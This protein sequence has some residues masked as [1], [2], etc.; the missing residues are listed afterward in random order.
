MVWPRD[1]AA[2]LSCHKTPVKAEHTSQVMESFSIDKPSDRGIGRHKGCRRC[3]P[4]LRYNA[5]RSQ[6][7]R[8]SRLAQASVCRFIGMHPINNVV[9]ITNYTY[10]TRSASRCIAF[11]AST[12]YEGRIVVHAVLSARNLPLDGVERKLEGTDLMICDGIEP[13]CIAGVFGG[14]D[15]GV[16]EATTDIFLESAC[17]NPTSVRRTARRLRA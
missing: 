13:K 11:D 14:L 8:E 1:L 4:L 6:G 16:T 3:Y 12:L 5:S 2:W 9:D 15:S 7:G 10:S 17:F